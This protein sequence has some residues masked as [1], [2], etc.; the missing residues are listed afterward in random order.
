M[1]IYFDNAASTV[2]SQAVAERYMEVLMNN[3]ANPA[4]QSRE[5]MEAENI[6]K[7]SAE[8]I[9]Y[10]I[11]SK[12]SEIYFTSG[13]TESNNWAIFGTAFGY[14]RN[15]RHIITTAVEHPAV[16]KPFNVLREH[17]FE[18]TVLDVDSD[19]MVKLDALKKAIRNDTTL[20]SVMLVNNETGLIQPVSEIGEIIKSS[21]SNTL[22]HVDAVQGFGKMNI[23]VVKCKIDLLSASGHKFHAPKG[24]GFLYMKDGMKV[25]PLMYGG[26]HQRGQRPGTENAAGAAALAFAA[27]ECRFEETAEC[28]AKI[29]EYISE[30]I[31]SNIEG[32][33]IN[34]GV[35][36]TS[37]YVLNVRFDSLRAPV[38]LNALDEKGIVV[39]AG[40]A[41]GSRKKSLSGVLKAMGLSDEE[42][43]GSVRI[44]FSRFSTMEEAHVFVKTLEEIVPVLRR[45]NRKR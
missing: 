12:P 43:E 30:Y 19:G 2:P 7:Q 23:D 24:T 4:G 8:K 38:L 26:G 9:A 11:K 40:S 34:G 31:L 6:I 32:T 25:R 36:K 21:N 39:S 18:V 13:G 33:H 29:K 35:E 45:F 17:G 37:P 16:E 28:V 20:V 15:G 3:F 14:A 1:K 44:S 22:F 5:A 42:V 27:E 10:I 41:C